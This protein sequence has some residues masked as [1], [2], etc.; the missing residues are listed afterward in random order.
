[1]GLFTTSQLS[2][3]KQAVKYRELI[4]KEAVIGGK[5]FGPIP[6]NGR[7][8]FFC[9]DERTWVW[10]EEWQDSAG[11]H[12]VLTTRYDVRPDGVVKTQNNSH[13]TKVSPTEAHHLLQAATLYKERVQSQLYADFQ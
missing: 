9:L 8:E 7:R 4:R 13:Y 3:K 10:H 12:H 2:Q 11:T 6:K 1:M 5:I